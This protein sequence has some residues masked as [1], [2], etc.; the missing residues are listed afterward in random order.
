MGD[1]GQSTTTTTNNENDNHAHPRSPGSAPNPN[2]TAPRTEPV[3]LEQGSASITSILRRWRTEDLVRQSGL[4][5][6]GF[7][8]AF[9]FLSFIIMAANKHGGWMDYDN[10][11]EYRYC[12]SI[13]T[14]AGFYTLCQVGRQIHELMT[15]KELVRRPMILYIDFFGDQAIILFFLGCPFAEIVMAYLLL[16]ASSAAVPQ[17]NKFRENNDNSFTDMSS[18]AISMSIFAFACLAAS[19]LVSG[20][21]LSRQTYI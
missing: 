11:E 18:A 9:S 2:A 7:A 19:S 6:R 13:A 21:K 8:L 17:T 3:D 14:I 5:L 12:L 1:F 15:G 4:V 16:S 10:Y 20:F